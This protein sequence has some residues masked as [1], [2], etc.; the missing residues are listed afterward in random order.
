LGNRSLH[1]AND[2]KKVELELRAIG[3]FLEG[4]VDQPIVQQ[5]KVD[6]VNRTF[7]QASPEQPDLS[8]GELLN[9]TALGRVIDV[10]AKLIGR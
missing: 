6:F 4:V 5:A 7:G 10:L 2:S 9:V 3:P 8:G 1:R